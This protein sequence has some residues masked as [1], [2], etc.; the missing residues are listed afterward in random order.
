MIFLRSKYNKTK[1][2]YKDLLT[3]IAWSKLQAYIAFKAWNESKIQR[4]KFPADKCNLDNLSDNPT[5]E[6]QLSSSEFF[7]QDDENS[8]KDFNDTKKTPPPKIK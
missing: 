1:G 4:K 7:S 3:E 8:E 2:I 6:M 5:S